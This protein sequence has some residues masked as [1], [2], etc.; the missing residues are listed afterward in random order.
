MLRMFVRQG[1]VLGVVGVAVALPVAY[2]AA[3]SMGALLFGVPPTDP[4]IYGAAIV[5]TLLMTL[6]G[7]LQPAIRAAVIDPAITMRGE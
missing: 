5:L 6:A 7:S 4:S 2:L 1:M 3:R